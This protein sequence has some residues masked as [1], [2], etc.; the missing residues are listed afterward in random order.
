MNSLQKKLNYNF[1][2]LSLLKQ[3]LTHTSYAHEN[4]QVGHNERLEF[5]GDAVLELSI[6]S[7][8][9]SLFPEA[10]EG[11]LTRMRSLLVNA[12]TLAE[13]AHELSIPDLILLT[14]GE[15]AQ[16]GRTR[17]SLLADTV[18]AI[19][20]S[21]Y[22]DGGFLKAKRSI[23]KLYAQRWPTTASNPKQKD[24]KTL[25]QEFAQHEFKVLPI[26]TLLQ[27]SGKEHAKIFEVRVQLPGYEFTAMGKS[28]KIAS[29]IAA[30][31]ALERLQALVKI[32]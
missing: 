30:K 5:L 2:D 21:I 12:P 17:P 1:K 26:Y 19:L 13:I 20:G 24:Y 4:A 27:S 3:A 10:R 7:Q 14:K 31:E 18:E 29:Q 15:E 9:F 25:L 8:L 23:L 28:L 11:D 6:S 22:L 16:G 32:D